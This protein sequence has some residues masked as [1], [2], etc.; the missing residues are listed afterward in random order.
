MIESLVGK[1]KEME[2]QE[3]RTS[4][5]LIRSSFCE[6]QGETQIDEM[7]YERYNGVVTNLLWVNIN[8]L[9]NISS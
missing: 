4:W 2:K 8:I 6:I 7:T 5:L 3:T 9:V 1:L